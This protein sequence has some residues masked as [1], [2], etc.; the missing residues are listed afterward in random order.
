M[1]ELGGFWGHPELNKFEKN[2]DCAHRGGQEGALEAPRMDFGAHFGSLFDII[3]QLLTR[4]GVR[5][6]WKEQGRS[7]IAM[8]QR[9]TKN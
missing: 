1:E 4:H 7:A 6:T 2:R 5:R 3:Q 8:K 9:R